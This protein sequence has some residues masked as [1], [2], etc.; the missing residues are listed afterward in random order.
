MIAQ[1]YTLFSS[2]SRMKKTK[3]SISASLLR[4]PPITSI[5]KSQYPDKNGGGPND[6]P[7]VGPTLD[8]PPESVSMSRCRYIVHG[9]Q[10][11]VTHRNCTVR[12]LGWPHRWS[13]TS[14]RWSLHCERPLH[15][16]DGSFDEVQLV[17]FTKDSLETKFSH[18][19]IIVNRLFCKTTARYV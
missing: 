13:S 1:F 9:Y 7:D 3:L 10:P 12:Y 8:Q 17:V 6:R 16:A 2:L 14:S 5:R 15:L 11:L 4:S 18:T 19:I